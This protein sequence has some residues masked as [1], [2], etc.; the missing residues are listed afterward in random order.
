MKKSGCLGMECGYCRTRCPAFTSVAL[1]SSTARGKA[2]IL[3]AYGKDELRP[4][5]LVEASYIC[6]RCGYCDEICPV[7]AGAG[8]FVLEMRQEVAGSDGVP[9][10]LAAM[11]GRMDETGTPYGER[12]TDWMRSAGSDKESDKEGDE[13]KGSLFSRRQ[14]SRGKSSRGRVGYFPGCTI[15]AK[16]PG[17]AAKT[18][19][20]LRHCGMDP[21]PVGQ[22]CC[23]SPYINAGVRNRWE[24]NARGVLEFFKE[25]HIRELV[26]S[27]PGC[28]R[29]FLED[30]PGLLGKNETSSMPEIVHLSMF[31]EKALADRK[32]P[33]REM[34]GKAI[35][36]DPCHLGRTFGIIEEPRTIIRAAGLELEEFQAHGRLS[37]CCG[38]G[39]VL[40]VYRREE[41]R[42][43]L[44]KRAAEVR[45]KKVDYLISACGHCEERFRSFVEEHRE[46]CSFK[47]LNIVEIFD[48]EGP[49]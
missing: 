39:G 2:R 13:N 8:E 4:G 47:V 36:H 15:Q 48:N 18:V 26:V 33:V 40:Q 27:C 42:E 35:Y 38:G 5:D 22:L 14:G 23:G 28:A 9:H 20:L 30:Y 11:L 29:A 16:T 24:E 31:L 43:P 37:E 44:E 6:A 12:D 3:E 25:N 17:L 34:S 49:G 10:E 7:G 21:L 32:L 1:E 45:E 19:E 41:S 46:S